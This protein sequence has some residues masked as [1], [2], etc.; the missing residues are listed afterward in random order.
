V[1]GTNL[2]IGCAELLARHGLARLVVDGDYNPVEEVIR[3][4][5]SFSAGFADVRID[6]DL[7]LVRVSRV[8]GAY[9]AGSA[10]R[11]RRATRRSAASFAA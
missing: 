7:G 1:A 9:D 6:P 3:R 4:S 10:I 5:L 8:V 2:N 11:R